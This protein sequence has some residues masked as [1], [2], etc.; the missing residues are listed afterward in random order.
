[1]P[2]P[3]N[4]LWSILTRFEMHRQTGDISLGSA[5]SEAIA[6]IRE[7]HEAET[8]KCLPEERPWDENNADSIE[9]NTARA[10]NSAIYQTR[11]K[12]EES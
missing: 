9:A 2:R 3:V 5:R 4:K 11:K 1:M 10:F 12:T 7:W 8:L 6:A